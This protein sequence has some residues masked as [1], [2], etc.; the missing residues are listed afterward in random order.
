MKEKKL[1]SGQTIEK[2]E[3]YTMDYSFYDVKERKKHS[4]PLR[5]MYDIVKQKANNE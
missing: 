4:L 3:L 2:I 1:C 5:G